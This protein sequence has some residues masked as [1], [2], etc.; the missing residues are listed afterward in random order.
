M[1]KIN[2]LLNSGKIN[3]SDLKRNNTNQQLSTSLYSFNGSNILLNNSRN[4][5]SNGNKKGNKSKFNAYLINDNQKSQQQQST[6]P[7]LSSSPSLTNLNRKKD[8][9]GIN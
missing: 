5:I 3:R 2:E 9:N 8:F 6:P 7:S 1:Q 4:Y